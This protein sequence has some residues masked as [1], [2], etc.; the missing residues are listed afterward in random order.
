MSVTGSSPGRGSASASD[1][2]GLEEGSQERTGDRSVGT[3]RFVVD[4]GEE[5]ALLGEEELELE[6]V[7]QPQRGIVEVVVLREIDDG[8]DEE[9]VE[10]AVAVV[11]RRDPLLGAG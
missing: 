9:E 5:L 4:L 6:E 10:D 1:P 11:R 8:G 3:R 7:T 2:V